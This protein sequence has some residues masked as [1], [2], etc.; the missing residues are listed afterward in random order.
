M[1]DAPALDLAQ[2]KATG[3]LVREAIAA[4][5]VEAAHDIGEGGLLVAL[6]EMA[7]ASGLGADVQRL[8][9][10]TEAYFGEPCASYLLAMAEP[11]LLLTR[12]AALG[13]EASI[14]GQTGGE[15]MRLAGGER[16]AISALADLHAAWMPAYMN[17]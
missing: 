2:E 1:I 14:I 5:W 3:T 17:S 16:V 12:A 10:S 15:E 7:L 8:E 9:A 13:L 11:A 6:A 4:G